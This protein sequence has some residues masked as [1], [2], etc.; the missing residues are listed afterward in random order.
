M[1]R[2]ENPILHFIGLPFSAELPGSL[3]L[4]TITPF[5]VDTFFIALFDTTGCPFL[6][7]ECF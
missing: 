2:T 4:P 5:P 3:R 6:T 7:F 1:P